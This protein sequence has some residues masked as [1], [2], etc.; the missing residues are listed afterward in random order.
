M[1]LKIHPEV[2]DIIRGQHL[3]HIQSKELEGPLAMAPY[4]KVGIQ[5][6]VTHTQSW[7]GPGEDGVA[8]RPAWGTWSIY[9]SYKGACIMLHPF[10]VAQTWTSKPW[11]LVGGDEIEVDWGGHT[12]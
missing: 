11:S 2:R 7:R 6:Q 9:H 1:T 8:G 5:Q 3:V 12:G 10:P 4:S